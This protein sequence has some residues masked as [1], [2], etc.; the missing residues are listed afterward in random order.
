MKGTRVLRTCARAALLALALV[1]LAATAATAAVRLPAVIG[2]NMV[3]QCDRPVPLWGWATPGRQV[4]V[5]IGERKAAAAANDRGEWLVRLEPMAASA[6]PQVL[7]VTDEDGAK[8][9]CGNVLIGEVWLGSGQSNMEM[10]LQGSE[11][12]KEFAQAA[13]LP[14][15]RLL[16]VPRAVSG[17]PRTDVQA[18]WKVCSPATVP[19][20]SAVLYEFGRNL[21]QE[22]KVPVGL[23]ASSWGGT[24]IEPWTPPEGFAAVPALKNEHDWLA[25]A[26][27][28]Y[29]REKAAAIDKAAKWLDAARAAA[30]E[31]RAI[32][33]PP[34]WPQ[35]AVSGNQQPTA[36]YNGM[37]R[38]LAPFAIRG[39]IWYQG[40]AN[41]GAGMRYFDLMKGLIQG[42]RQVWGEGDFPFYYVQIAPYRYGADA[43]AL[44]RLW[45]AQTATLALPNTGMAVTVDIATVGD[46]H[47]PNK[48]EVGRR[49]ALWAL[50]RD[51]GRKD[52][53][54][55]GPL[56]DKHEIDGRN[57]TIQFTHADGGL[58]SR[59]GKPLTWFTVAGEDKTF[60]PANA[61]IVGDAVVVTCPEIEHPAA[62]RFG[63]NHI[64]EPNLANEAGLPASPFRTDKW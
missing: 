18:Q 31:G 47:P 5:A 52:L 59:D 64:A 34:P 9:V 22:L 24:R 38:P 2:E 49:L 3:L 14:A 30:A 15:I 46:I 43:Q 13:D 33:E 63:W 55:S 26:N 29:E 16:I 20:F 4:T 23:I 53:V 44:P 48:H 36:L 6:E 35:H 28:A 42:W 8:V 57:V 7:T 58:V 50:A 19:G 32:P 1:G 12:G 10:A 17:T 61:E 51:Y 45:E 25:Q 40:E 56:Y 37:I 21:H 54:Y 60:L 39:A 41:V 27:A 62:V 11:G